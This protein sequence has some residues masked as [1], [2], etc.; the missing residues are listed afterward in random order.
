MKKPASRALLMLR[1]LPREPKAGT[2][3]GSSI[4][5]RVSVSSVRRASAI[6]RAAWLR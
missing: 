1:V 2:E 6:S 4:L 3:T 5:F